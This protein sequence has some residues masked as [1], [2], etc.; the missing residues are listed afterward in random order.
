MQVHQFLDGFVISLLSFY[1]LLKVNICLG[2][3]NIV[4]NFRSHA[5]SLCRSP[6]QVSSIL[7]RDRFS[8]EDIVIILNL[9]NN[10]LPEN[11]LK[12]YAH[13]FAV[14]G[15]NSLLFVYDILAISLEN[16]LCCR[17]FSYI[18]IHGIKIFLIP[19]HLVN[20]LEDLHLV[21]YFRGNLLEW[22]KS[23]ISLLEIFTQINKIFL[24]HI[25]FADLH[26]GFIQVLK[27]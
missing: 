1:F 6:I 15:L 23:F 17:V 3:I 13:D 20:L 4:C 24:C 18:L 5:S 12:K 8:D 2:I 11:I 14:N 9:C 22:N 10:F 27:S 19:K 26:L 21:T 16:S 7:D 25:L